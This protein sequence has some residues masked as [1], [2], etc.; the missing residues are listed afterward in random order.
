MLAWLGFVGCAALILIAGPVLTRSA[1]AI[2]SATGATR[3][4][5][6]L[7]L[8]ATATSLPELFTGLSSVTIANAPNIAVGDALGSCMFNLALLA[9]LDLLVRDEPIYRKVDQGHILTA[10]LGVILIGFVGALLIVARGPL[11]LRIWHLSLYTPVI[12]LLYGIAIRA[13]FLHE[14]DAPNGNRPRVRGQSPGRHL[15]WPAAGRYLLAAAVVAVAGGVLPFTGLAIAEAMGWKASFVGTLLIAAATSLPELV[16]MIAA[17]RLGSVDLAMAGLLGSNLFD[18]LVIAIDDLAYPSGSL[19]AAASPAH[20]GS[21]FVAVVMSG[22]VIAAVLDRPRVRLF[23]TVGWISIALM[24]M[25]LLGAYAIYLM[26][27]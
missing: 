5:I 20:A 18:I 2:A 21:A 16:V 27:H 15:L 11:D 13:A 8:L 4:W 3:T 19:I 10:A 14:R 22:I 23:G 26:G 6:G 1:E 9:L 24:A 17:L 7:V 25:Y 12:I